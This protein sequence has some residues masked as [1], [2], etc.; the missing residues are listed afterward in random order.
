MQPDIGAAIF[1]KAS[2][3]GEQLL[4]VHKIHPLM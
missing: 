1:K 2:R 4:K 3:E